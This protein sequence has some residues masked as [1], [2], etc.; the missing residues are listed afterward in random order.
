MCS[1]DLHPRFRPH[2]MQGW[3]PDFIPR[4]T[5]DALASQYV[6]R[7]VPVSGTESLR[8]SRVLA[9]KEGI[10][11]GI[12]G[13]VTLDGSL[14]VARETQAA[15]KAHLMLPDTGERDRSEELSVWKEWFVA[16]TTRCATS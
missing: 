5:G 1:S 10:L 8:L 13:G 12:T 9:L 2:L 14:R 7:I 4:L 11:T 16:L 15:S 3:T 6:D